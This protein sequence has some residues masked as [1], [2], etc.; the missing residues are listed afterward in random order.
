MSGGF[1][2]RGVSPPKSGKI[3]IKNQ[4]FYELRKRFFLFKYER[5]YVIFIFIHTRN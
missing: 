4:Q 3:F 5:K 2:W 1:T